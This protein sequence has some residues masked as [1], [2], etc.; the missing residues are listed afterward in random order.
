MAKKVIRQPG[1]RQLGY[2]AF[3]FFALKG[4]IWIG[5]LLSAV[6]SISY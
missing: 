1:I 2:Y 3:L 5:I 4:V 6:W